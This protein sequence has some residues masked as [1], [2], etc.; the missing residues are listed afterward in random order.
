MK[1]YPTI[2]KDLIEKI[3][4][5]PGLGGKSAER[6]TLYLINAPAYEAESLAEAIIKVKREL[7]LCQRCFHLAEGDLCTI[8]SDPSR[9]KEEICVVETVSDLIAIEQ[10]GIF[11]GLYHVLHGALNPIEN[12]GPDEIHLREL[13]ERVHREPVREVIIATNPSAQGEV[14]A[15]YILKLLQNEK[16]KVTR[17]GF[18]IP[19]G[20]DIKYVDKM[21]ISQ[22]ILGRRPFE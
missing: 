22:A 8:C 19:M 4:R 20:G 6:L 12:V 9:N 18:G 1:A 11:K 3:K 21:T 2:V 7:T 14:T 13:V 10:T 15:H 17:I 5:L 16:V